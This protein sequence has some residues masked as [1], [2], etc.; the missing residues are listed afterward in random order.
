MKKIIGLLL[1][2]FMMVFACT[3]G[4][5]AER[6]IVIEMTDTGSR[7]NNGNPNAKTVLAGV[8]ALHEGQSTTF[9]ESALDNYFSY[10]RNVGETIGAAV[11]AIKQT[12]HLD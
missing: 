9:W 12:H 10:S 11:Y 5:F 7:W 8:I 4:A 6:S 3:T 1:I 2:V